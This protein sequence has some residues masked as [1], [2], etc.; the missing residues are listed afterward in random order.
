MMNIGDTKAGTLV[1]VDK[2]G[3]K[4]YENLQEELPRMCSPALSVEAENGRDRL[5]MPR[6]S[7]SYRSVRDE[8]GP[9]FFCLLTRHTGMTLLIHFSLL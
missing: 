9:V 3:N 7:T 6:Y 1:G 5:D 4:F 8:P 2:Y